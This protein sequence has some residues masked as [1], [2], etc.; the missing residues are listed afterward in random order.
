[1]ERMNGQLA[2]RT[3][4]CLLLRTD[5]YADTVREDSQVT[6]RCSCSLA[7]FALQVSLTMVKKNPICRLGL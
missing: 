5:V 2:A 4:R 6:P 1:M 3:V 7:W